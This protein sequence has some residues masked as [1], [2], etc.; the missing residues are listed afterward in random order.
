MKKLSFRLQYQ[1]ED[2]TK[3]ENYIHSDFFQVFTK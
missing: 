2:K 3:A 1:A